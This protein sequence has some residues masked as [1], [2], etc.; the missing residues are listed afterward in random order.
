MKQALKM[1]L[2]TGALAASSLASAQVST[3]IYSSYGYGDGQPFA[4]LVGTLDTPDIMFATDT[5]YNWHPF[6]LG[7][8]GAQSTATID[9]GS[10]GS[11]TFSL[12]SD[13][14]SS[15][16]ID[17]VQWIDNGGGHGPNTVSATNML[18]AGHHSVTVNF[19]ED[20]GGESG[21]D[22]YLPQGVT[23]TTAVP[24]P[25]TTAMLLAGLAAMGLTAR[26]RRQD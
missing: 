22:L 26:R 25:A 16:Y 6:G 18:S 14:G 2:M 4:G 10:T 15:L 1:L 23:Y 19:Y 20:F 24:E 21:V 7:A 3:S 17:G 5:G 11:Y 8:F 9:V 12:N 13:D